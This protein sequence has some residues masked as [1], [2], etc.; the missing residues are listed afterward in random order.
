MEKEERD[1]ERDHTV[2]V[3]FAR[4]SVRGWLASEASSVLRGMQVERTA[5]SPTE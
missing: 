4:R 3:L 2:H 5:A 1:R